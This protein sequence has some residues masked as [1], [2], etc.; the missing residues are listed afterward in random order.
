LKLAKAWAA[1]RNPLPYLT[2]VDSCIKSRRELDW[3]R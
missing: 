1:S 3:T 2:S